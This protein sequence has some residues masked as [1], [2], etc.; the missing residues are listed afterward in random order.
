MSPVFQNVAPGDLI[1]ADYFNLLL[2]EVNW[3]V[4][5]VNQLN[6]RVTA[7]EHAEGSPPKGKE[8]KETKD[9]KEGKEGKDKLEFKEGKLEAKE[10]EKASV[11]EKAA[12]LEKGVV[13]KSA[14]LEKAVEKV[15]EKGLEKTVEK[16]SEKVTEKRFEK[17]TDVKTTDALANLPG[18]AGPLA[19]GGV[20]SGSTEGSPVRH[21]IPA[22]LRPDLSVS[23]LSGEGDLHG[24]D[25]GSG[26]PA[27]ANA[28]SRAGGST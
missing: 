25:S 21:F 6:A 12:A 7:L 24:S 20:P 17:L 15:V 18:S 14:A 27:R 2:N 9:T 3:L 1:T 19:S 16:V 23:A 13:E 22:A 5:T 28:G 4:D 10:I 11:V 8:T 26:A